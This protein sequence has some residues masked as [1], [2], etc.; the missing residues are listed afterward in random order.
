[1]IKITSQIDMMPLLFNLSGLQTRS[2][3]DNGGA[4]ATSG[5]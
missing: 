5:A 2:A 4:A 1:M 3:F